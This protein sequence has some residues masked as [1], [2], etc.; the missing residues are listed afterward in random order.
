MP[1]PST[2]EVSH[3]AMSEVVKPRLAGRQSNDATQNAAVY[4]SDVRVYSRAISDSDVA[5]LF[6]QG[7]RSAAGAQS[8]PYKVSVAF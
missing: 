8:L 4:I 7:R 1:R 2:S 6:E 5:A 3:A